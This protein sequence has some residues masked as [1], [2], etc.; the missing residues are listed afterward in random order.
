MDFLLD[1]DKLGK[2]FIKIDGHE[3][4][5]FPDQFLPEKLS[6]SFAIRAS[7]ES[8]ALFSNVEVLPNTPFWPVE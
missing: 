7:D 5:S 1:V 3:P 8:V 2:G 6:G 4:I